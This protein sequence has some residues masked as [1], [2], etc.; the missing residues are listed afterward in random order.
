[1]INSSRVYI[2]DWQKELLSS[3]SNFAKL[4]GKEE[5]SGYE[6][7]FPWK[8]WNNQRLSDCQEEITGKETSKQDFD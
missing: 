7:L 6:V 8:T 2:I 5:L 3:L 4:K 1:M